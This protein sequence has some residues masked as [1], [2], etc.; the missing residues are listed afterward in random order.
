MA[1]IRTQLLLSDG[2]EKPGSS[3]MI[4]DVIDPEIERFGQYFQERAGG[5]LLSKFEKEILR[6]YIWWKVEVDKKS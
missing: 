2:E 3:N 4:S 5:G 6:A 1:R